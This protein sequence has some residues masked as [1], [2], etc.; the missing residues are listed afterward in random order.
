MQIKKL[1][2]IPVLKFRRKS[3]ITIIGMS[4]MVLLIIS[5]VTL[6][7]SRVGLSYPS[8]ILSLINFTH[9][10]FVSDIKASTVK[11][12]IP[13][14]DVELENQNLPSFS[15]PLYVHPDNPRY[16]TDGSGRAILLAGSHFWL[17]LQD[18][19]RPDPPQAFDYLGWLDF[20]DSYNHNFFR[21][22][23]WEQ[24][25]WAV[26]SSDEYYFTPHPYLR[27]GPGIGLDGKPKFDLTQLDQTY[28]DRLRLR[29]IEAGQ[30]GMYVSIMLF[31]GWSIEYPKGG[32]AGSNPWNG[33]PYNVS[34]NINGINGDING[35]N[36]GAETHTLLIPE[37][38]AL[39][40]AYVRKVIDTVNDL[41]N[42]LYEISNESPGNS[43]DW[44]YHVINYIRA[45]QETL[46]KQHPV[47][48]TV[49][50]PNGSNADL[51]ASNADWI[52]PNGDLN[53]PPP[54]DGSKVILADTDHLC[55]ICGDRYWVW[56]SFLRGEN[57]IFMDQY[58][59][60]YK[61][62]GGGYNPN[63][64]TDV[65]L[66]ENLGYIR[67]Y[68]DRVNLVAMTPRGDLA[69]SNYALANPV[70]EGAEYLVYFPDGGSVTVNLS[71]TSGELNIEW[72][73][74]QNGT[75]I[76]GG[77]VIGGGLR[78]FTAPFDGDAVL[79]IYDSDISIPTPQFT[80]SPTP[81]SAPTPTPDKQPPVITNI[82]A[83]S[84]DTYAYI[85]WRTDEPATS[86]VFYGLNE[87]SLDSS[88]SS[89]EY[90]FNHILQLSALSPDTVYY[91]RIESRDIS[92]NL[93]STNVLNFSTMKVGDI[94]R[95]FLPTILR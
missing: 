47:G 75:V 91:Y 18:G 2:E 55:G 28:F 34:N 36:S 86:T 76:D 67:V 45:Y 70:S 33:H 60:S 12:H 51:F 7:D 43:Q 23:V 17:N 94:T 32:Y 56:K 63:N 27:T 71:G 15:G 16:F 78:F 14:G 72:F 48:M 1:L 73:N 31:N 38:T 81:K 11:T 26:E 3:R 66:R 24:A 54:A 89:V 21:L 20:L 62:H 77:S 6:L 88:V 90:V 4:V 59:D 10:V 82:K 84:L 13:I 87:S 41:D 57:P 69:S 95:V 8:F 65:S 93:A 58:D 42:V 80:P 44:Q 50:W 49:E 39:Q 25:R 64:P 9:S 92:G 19:V 68:A 30:R 46:P 53:N 83:V 61:L 5:S 35:D 37:V 74:P 29:V 85:T 52:S 40:E 79:Y 22:W